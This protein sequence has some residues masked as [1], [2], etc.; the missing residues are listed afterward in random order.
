M[1]VTCSDS[2]KRYAPLTKL[3]GQKITDAQYWQLAEGENGW[4]SSNLSWL[5]TSCSDPE[6]QMAGSE[7]YM[8]KDGKGNE[9]DARPYFPLTPYLLMGEIIHRFE[10]GR[11]APNA[12]KMQGKEILEG[13]TGANFRGAG[14]MV[15]D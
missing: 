9:F 13:I 4:S 14:P 6:N 2:G 7:W 15:D 5:H 10:D 3:E 12:L 8:L 1:N 11:P